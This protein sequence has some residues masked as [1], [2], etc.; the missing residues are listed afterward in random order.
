MF[1]ISNIRYF[2]S[3]MTWRYWANQIQSKP[4]GEQE[5]AINEGPG[6]YTDLFSA[7]PLVSNAQ[8]EDISNAANRAAEEAGIALAVYADFGERIAGIITRKRTAD[9]AFDRDMEL[10][11]RDFAAKKGE[12]EL[13]VGLHQAYTRAARPQMTDDTQILA[14]RVQDLFD[15]EH[16][17]E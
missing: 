16:D 1:S 2:A 10:L 13:R 3:G 5:T 8:L 4:V 15:E 9:Q 6:V 12:A 17:V 14:N 11:T 7:S